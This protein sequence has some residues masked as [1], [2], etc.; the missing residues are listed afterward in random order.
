MPEYNCDRMVILKNK[1]QTKNVKSCVRESD[2][3]WKVTFVKGRSLTYFNENVQLLSNPIKIKH[4]LYKF[5]KDNNL[6]N[7]IKAVYV[8]PSEEG[9]YYHFYF[10][11]GKEGEYFP[12]EIVCIDSAEIY[13]NDK[14]VLEYFKKL[15]VIKKLPTEFELDENYLQK[16]YEKLFVRENSALSVYLGFSEN[17]KT[18]KKLTP[19][20]PFG[21]NASQYK[22][23]VNFLNNQIS[24][25][26][27]PPGTGKTQ[28]ILNIVSNILIQ[29]KNVQIVSNNNSAVENIL[30]KMS[31]YDFDFFIAELGKNENKSRFIEK[32]RPYPDFSEWF[33]RGDINELAREIVALSDNVQHLF[34]IQDRIAHLNQ[35]LNNLKTEKKHFDIYKGEMFGLT[36]KIEIAKNVSSEKILKILNDFHKKAGKK[37]KLS[38]MD[39]LITTFRFGLK[40]YK[41]SARKLVDMIILLQDEFY[42]RKQQELSLEIERLN[43]EVLLSGVRV[44]D[45]S[46]KSMLY[47]KDFIARYYSKSGQRSVFEQ[48]DLWKHGRQVLKE[49]PVILSTTYSSGNSLTESGESVIY[50]YL[51]MDEASQVDVV[52]GSLSMAYANSAVIVGD[53]KQ[54][55]NVINNVD[56]LL[57]NKI[58]NE[59]ENINDGYEYS[60]S[61][62][63]SL[64]KVIDPPCVLLKEHYRCHPKIIN[65][66]NQKYYSG[67]LSIMTIDKGE[68][69]VITAIKTVKGNHV[70]G[71]ANIRQIEVIINEVLPKLDEDLANVGIIAPYNAQ[72][73]EIKHMIPEVEVATVHKYQGREKDTIIISTVDDEVNDF[74][75]DPYLINVAISRAK[76]KLYVITSDNEQPNGSIKDLVSYIEY[77]NCEVIESKIYSVFDFL[78]KQ[79]SEELT[80]FNKKNKSVSEYVSENL[81][82][83]L[84]KDVLEENEYKDLDVILHYPLR[85]LIKDVSLLNEAERRYAMNSATHIDFLIYSRIAK[86]TILA[87]EVDGY[88]YHKA[89]TKQAERDKMKNEILEK[90]NIPIIRFSTNGSREREI[91]VEKLDSINL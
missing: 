46:N 59:F 13:V 17:G 84:I 53:S 31:H 57:S 66:C 36:E 79:Y 39:R 60:N 67:E 85:M 64:I 22:A 65:F 19:I 11:N 5:Y 56:R 3:R 14:S 32:Q 55:P 44:E 26:Q 54:L 75:D 77:N 83:Y 82:Y 35:E 2:G 70:R 30:D 49:Y 40:F 47:F 28:T 4:K 24:V 23:V 72:V 51:I 91:L 10:E 52:T 12:N 15:S 7:N 25:I 45:L 62:L 48:D 29:G 90:Y 34:D 81:M 33:F 43:K 88:Q 41:I 87:I 78:Y 16:K 63:N 58:F 76:K 68:D 42:L 27:G 73:D 8:F 20:F 21:C 1:I 38:F 61:F 6:L 69:N 89:G 74:S 80:K 37:E 71:H 18:A 9:D 86:R 50:D